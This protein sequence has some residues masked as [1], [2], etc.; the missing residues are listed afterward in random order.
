M[1]PPYSP[2]EDYALIGDGLTAALISRGGSIDWACFPRFDSPSVFARMLDA[3]AGGTWRIT[4]AEDFVAERH[5]VLDT[6]VLVTTFRTDTGRAELVD[7][8]PVPSTGPDRLG[9][10]AIVRI[11]RGQ[12]GVVAFDW[13][14]EPRFDYGRGEAEWSL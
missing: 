4:P 6:N 10:S 9:D 3:D 11:L 8:M 7:F 14:F 1:S 5:Y 13:V 2:I 12:E